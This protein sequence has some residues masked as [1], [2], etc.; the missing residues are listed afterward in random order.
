MKN[1]E[2]EIKRGASN[3]EQHKNVKNMAR[4]KRTETVN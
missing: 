4:R 1:P 2:P 3:K